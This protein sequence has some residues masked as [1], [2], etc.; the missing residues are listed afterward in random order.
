VAHVARKA[1]ALKG[2]CIRSAPQG[3][4]L[5]TAGEIARRQ[6]HQTL[7]E[8]KVMNTVRSNHRSDEQLDAIRHETG[9]WVVRGQQGQ[10]LCRAASFQE[11]LERAQ[12]YGVAGSVVVAVCRLPGED[13]LVFPAQMDR[14]RTAIAVLEPLPMRHARRSSSASIARDTT[15]PPD[16]IAAE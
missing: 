13:I 12:A 11:S 9:H 4:T 8:K 14:L 16:A 10:V 3:H 1:G 15:K 7:R 6:L 5:V 2:A